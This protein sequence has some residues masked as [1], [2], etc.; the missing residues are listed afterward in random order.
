VNHHA[1]P[2]PEPVKDPLAL[3]LGSLGA[4]VGFGGACLT[5]A[6]I[7]AAVLRG[8][9]EPGGYRDTAAYPLLAGLIL[10]IG[11][12]G[13]FGWY[14]SFALDNIWQRGVIAVLGA[15]GALLVGFLGAPLERFFGVL[16]LIAWLIVNIVFGIISNRWAIRGKGDAGSGVGTA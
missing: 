16:G 7:V 2:P 6:Q 8:E 14:R 1:P 12:G 5:A 9:L 13:G 10:A 15:V 4:G 3:G 11:V